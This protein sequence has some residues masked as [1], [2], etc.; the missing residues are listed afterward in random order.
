MTK[1]LRGNKKKPPE[2]KGDLEPPCHRV[3]LY[4][5]RRNSPPDTSASRGSLGRD[6]LSVQHRDF[7]ADDNKHNRAGSLL[8]GREK[9][10][11]ERHPPGSHDSNKRMSRSVILK[12]ADHCDR[13]TGSVPWD[14]SVPYWL[15]ISSSGRI[16]MQ[17]FLAPL[18]HP[19][20]KIYRRR[21]LSIGKQ[22]TF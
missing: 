11:L 15:R 19:N 6:E 20:A 18:R 14:N 9:T 12:L 22:Q 16:A 4:E 21:L 10:V 5:P 8:S 2:L 1:P 13:T 3:V 7:Q 17:S